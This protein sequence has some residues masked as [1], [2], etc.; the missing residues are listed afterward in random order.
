ML[1]LPIEF[2]D[3]CEEDEIDDFSL[4]LISHDVP[5]KFSN[6]T[7]VEI[8]PEGNCFFRSLSR[9]VYGNEGHHLK[10]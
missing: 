6:H 2:A 9:F 10:M 4:T 5:D 7:P 1:A 8:F 3:E